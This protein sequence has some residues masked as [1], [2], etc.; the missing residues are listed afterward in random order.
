MVLS[1][2][3]ILTFDKKYFEKTL[4]FFLFKIVCY[5]VGNSIVIKKE[6]KSWII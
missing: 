1:C 6:E 2:K 3:F 4:Q 5:Y